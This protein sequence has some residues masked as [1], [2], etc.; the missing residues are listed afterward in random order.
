MNQSVQRSLAMLVILLAAGGFYA[1]NKWPHRYVWPAAVQWV[2]DLRPL[3]RSTWPSP[4]LPWTTVTREVD[5]A[6]PAGGQTRNITA[7]VNSIGMRF[8]K[9]E[10]GTFHVDSGSHEIRQVDGKRPKGREVRLTHG[11]YLG[12]YEV[13]NKQYESF[14]PS[15]AGKRPEYQRGRFSDDQPVEPVTWQDAQ[16]FSRW[17]SQKEG[18]LCRLPTEAEWEYACRA[19]TESR[20]YWGDAFWDRNKAN[21]GGLKTVKETWKEDGFEYTAPVGAYPPNP[22]GL[23]DMIGNSWEWVQDWYANHSDGLEIDPQGPMHGQFRVYK[24]GNWG[25]RTYTVTCSARDGDD[26]ADLPDIRGF[27]VLCELDEARR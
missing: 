23:S 4:P 18:R 22:W 17:L 9:I 13:T 2:Q 6:T 5:V 21:L 20:L 7:Y 27:R 10:P 8:I 15:H 25:S 19:G 26:P 11:Y 3:D 1:W 12:E 24:G 16:R 14:D